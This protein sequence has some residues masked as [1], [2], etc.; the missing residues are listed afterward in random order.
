MN[1]AE[2]YQALIEARI[3]VREAWPDNA[4]HPGQYYLRSARLHAPG[5]ALVYSRAAIVDFF[6]E[7]GADRASSM[8]ASEAP[9]V[10]A[11]PMPGATLLAAHY[12]PASAATTC[13]SLA[14]MRG[15]WINEEWLFGPEP[16]RNVPEQ[17]EPKRMDLFSVFPDR[18]GEQPPDSMP[19]AAATQGPV[20]AV[21]ERFHRGCNLGQAEAFDAIYAQDATLNLADGET[22]PA[23]ASAADFYGRLWRRFSD[24]VLH[25]EQVV[26]PA[27]GD[28]AAVLWHLTG[29]AP[30]ASRQ[31]HLRGLSFWRF[32][33]AGRIVADSTRFDTAAM[34]RDRDADAAAWRA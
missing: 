18:V 22:G 30:N 13:L 1:A 11:A 2:R 27:E 34:Q 26:A 10:I 15:D 28:R 32:D 19:G 14:V 6:D 4:G 17:V 33:A 24:P 21:L 23:Q 20:A 25:A 5:G 3:G 8:A 12:R 7:F 29:D 31:Q 9:E 16:A